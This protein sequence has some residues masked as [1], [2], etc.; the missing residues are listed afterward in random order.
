MKGT[1]NNMN[2][3][4][5]TKKNTFNDVRKIEK[6]TRTKIKNGLSQPKAS[7]GTPIKK[8]RGGAKFMAQLSN[9]GG[10]SKATGGKG[11]SDGFNTIMQNQNAKTML[12][13]ISQ[14]N[15]DT[16]EMNGKKRL[17]KKK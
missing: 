1:T 7:T 4:P 8:L 6:A 11:I 14:L 2:E 9:I 3:N 13:T 10:G 12:Q 16:N 5:L 15:L 17:K